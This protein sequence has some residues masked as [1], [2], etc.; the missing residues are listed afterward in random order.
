[1][2]FDTVTLQCFLAVSDT[3]SFTKAADKV[4][5][6]QSAISQQIANLEDLLG[7]QLFT[8]GKRIALTN[9]GEV[10]YSYAR[11]LIAL[12]REAID[13]FREP[14]L[15]GEV[16]FGLPEDFAS[17]YLSDVLVDFSR[18]HP[19][20]L[21][22]VECDL[23]LN[24]YDR[25]RQNEF[26]LVLLKMSKPEDFPNGVEIWTES[27]E[28][29]NNGSTIQSDSPIPLVVSP[30]PCVY[31]ARAINALEQQGLKWRLSFISTSYASTLAAVKA[32]LGVTVLPQTMI[33]RELNTLSK[34]TM[35]ALDEIHISILKQGQ[36]NTAVNSLAGFVINK[37]S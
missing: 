5:R 11:Q 35:P 30:Q 7:K 6:S 26:D 21:L 2:S 25:F 28:W 23:T 15:K 27:L 34:S 37:L 3:S 10:F 36:D 29:V 24:L 32:G 17:M 1:M 19:R 31:R 9:D 18:L 33:P 14:D 12:Q 20:I 16:R 13:R 8:R 22:N 4:G